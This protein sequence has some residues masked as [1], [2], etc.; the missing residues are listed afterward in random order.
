[1]SSSSN[2]DNSALLKLLDAL[3][4]YDLDERTIKGTTSKPVVISI[5]G[6]GEYKRMYIDAREKASIKEFLGAKE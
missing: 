3:R 4:K 2:L 5:E 1:M 6:E